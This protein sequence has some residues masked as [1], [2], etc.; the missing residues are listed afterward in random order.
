MTL[1]FDYFYEKI[2]MDQIKLRNSAIADEIALKKW[3]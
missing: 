3:I 1:V 2:V